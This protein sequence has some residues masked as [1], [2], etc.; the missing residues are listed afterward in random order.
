M[1]SLQGADVRPTA[2]QLKAMND[3]LAAYRA[4]MA[5]WT[6]VKNVDV[7]SINATLTAAGLAPI[8]VR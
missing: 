6:A 3:A 8:T 4:A 2:L 7:R 1:N 5:K